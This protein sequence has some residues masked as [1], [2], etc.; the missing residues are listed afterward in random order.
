MQSNMEHNET[1]DV[2]QYNASFLSNRQLHHMIHGSQ[3]DRLHT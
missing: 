3:F 1:I 2:V